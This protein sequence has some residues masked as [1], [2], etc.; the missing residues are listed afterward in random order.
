MNLPEKDLG[1]LAFGI[2]TGI[3]TADDNIIDVAKR[4]INKNPEIIK[5]RDILC[6]TEAVVAIT[7]HNVVKLKDVTREIREKLKLKDDSVIGVLHPI[8]SR[9]RFSMLLKAISKVVPQGK[10]IV[11]FM[12]PDDEQGNPIIS[13]E[14][15]KNINKKHEDLISLADIEGQR[16]LH[17]ETGVDYIDFYDKIITENSREALLFLANSASYMTAQ[18]PDGII[19]SSVHNRNETLQEI[20]LQGFN[21][22]ITL[23]DICSDPEQEINSEFGLLGSNLLDP[24]N[25]QLKLCPKNSDKVCEEVKAMIKNEFNKDVEV[26][27]YGDGAYKDPESGIYELADPVS[28]FGCTENI[29][30]KNRIGVKTKYLMQKLYNEGKSKEEIAE[31]IEQERKDFIEKKDVQGFSAQ[32]TTP[33]K[34]ENLVSSLADLVSGSGD[35]NTPFVLVRGFL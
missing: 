3:I 31:I 35:T 22:V 19:V 1:V 26:I 10:V 2:K 29:R 7:Q 28:C 6:I 30:N 33:R 11:Q 12:F 9:N 20:R 13:K 4:T 14:T 24:A 8:L 27:I 23:Q 16:L 5:D 18:K 15:Q 25:E 21:N 32:G 17:P 34:I